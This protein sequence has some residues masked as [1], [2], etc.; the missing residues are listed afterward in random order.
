MSL[1]YDEIIDENATSAIRAYTAGGGKSAC[2][3]TF[4]CQ[5]NEADSEK[6]LGIL[7]SLGFSITDSYESCDLII[8][9]TCAVRAHAEEKVLSL[10]GNFK[11]L[12]RKNPELIIGVMGCM[13]AVLGTVNKLKRDF[14]YVS[15]T[16][17]AGAMHKLPELLCDVIKDGKRRFIIPDEREKIVEGIPV[18]RQSKSTAYVS[19]MYGCNNFCSYCIVPYTRGRERSRESAHILEECKRLILGGA[20]EIMLL[21]QNVN[22]YRADMDFPDLLEKIVE[23]PGDFKIRFMTSHP[24]DVS[25]RLIRVMSRNT[26]KISPIF[27]LPL[28]SGSDR[29]LSDMNRKYDRQ[30]FIGVAEKIKAEIP[31]VSLTTDVIVGY[32]GES[33]EDFL[34]T[35]DVLSRVR[36]DAV[37]AFLYSPRSGTRA[38]ERTDT[39]PDELKRERITRLLSMQDEISLEINRALLGK[40]VS[41]FGLTAEAGTCRRYSGR[42]NTGKLVHFCAEK[43]PTVDCVKVKITSAEPYFLIGEAQKLDRRNKNDKNY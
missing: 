23:I 42:T 34:E 13:G 11:A 29:I 28:Q 1:Y 33:E 19:I 38:A 14:H 5:Q 26:E 2:V 17:G 9:N 18:L 39:V 6:A 12:K 25:D 35:L 32:P 36:F 24:K 31:G 43:P 27:H 4:G 7:K 22:S 20:R 3:K 30:K 16:L 41:I 15:F 21:G 10:L 40:T 37:Y 8:L